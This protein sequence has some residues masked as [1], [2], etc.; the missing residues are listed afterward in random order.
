MSNLAKKTVSGLKWSAAERVATQIIQLII[1]IIL[2][3]M[4]GPEAF[5]LV[6]LLAVFISISQVFVDSGFSSALIR[7]QDVNESDFATTFYFNIFISFLLYFFLFFLAP[8][9]SDFYSQPELV[10]LTRVLSLTIIFN[11]FSVVQKARLTINIDFKTQANASLLSVIFSATVAYF[12]AY[13]GFGVWSLVF[14]TLS[15]SIANVILLN[16]LDFWYPKCGFSRA[17]FKNLFSF[18]S[19]LLVSSVIN[20][21]YENIYKIIIGKYFSVEQVG[22]FTQSRLLSSTPANTLAGIVARVT[23]PMQSKLQ[24]S[25][26]KL[27]EIYL[28]S[29]RMS[30]LLIFP[31]QFGLALIAKPL[32]LLLLGEEW[33][34]VASLMSILCL[35][36]IL[37]PVHSAN[38]NMLQVKGRSDL[39]LRLE[40]I[41][42]IIFTAMLILTVPLGMTAICIG[43]A[44]QSYLVLAV[45]TF[46]TGKVSGVSIKIQFKVLFRI[47]M[48][49]LFC[50][51]LGGFWVMFF[52][53]YILSICFSLITIVV[54]YIFLVKHTQPDIFDLLK[55]I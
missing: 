39:F 41:K 21:L 23:Y 54:F 30:C 53:D 34:D 12:V 55:K 11:A 28:L 35:G 17:S 19:R 6:G 44:V 10:Q 5:G 9:I 15:F 52:D 24:E 36:S 29:L 42:K 13:F 37:L 2:G 33:E 26:N 47:Y 45:N 32:V 40:I 51:I 31:L 20:T 43:I 48:V 27:T 49:A 16:M 1:M 46:Y 14:Q 22:I 8:V 38:L 18:S 7:K 3:R 4:L 25:D 50:T